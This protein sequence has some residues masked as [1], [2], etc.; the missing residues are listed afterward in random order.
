MFFKVSKTL[1]SDFFSKFEVNESFLL[2][3][4]IQSSKSLSLLSVL[5][6]Q[7]FLFKIK[8]FKKLTMLGNNEEGIMHIEEGIM[9]TNHNS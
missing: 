9:H 5:V 2:T 7:I 8:L 6:S 3:F 4:E 1:V